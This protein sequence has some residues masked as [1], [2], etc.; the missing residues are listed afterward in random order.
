M[1]PKDILC[2]LCKEFANNHLTAMEIYNE[3]VAARM[4]ELKGHGPI[5]VLV[6]LISYSDYFSKVRLVEGVIDCVF[7][8]H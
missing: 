4:E 7:F 6:E 3:L 2:I 8:M 5:E 1:A